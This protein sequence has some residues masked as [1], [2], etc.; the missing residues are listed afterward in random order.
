MK[1]KKFSCESCQELSN[2]IPLVEFLGKIMGNHCEVVLHDVTIPE[3]SVIAIANG[4]VSGRKVGAPITGYGLGLLHE[5][6]HLNQDFIHNYTS[7]LKNGKTAHS[8]T[9]FVKNSAGTVIGMLCINIDTDLLQCFRKG[10]DDIVCGYF[11]TSIINS[12]VSPGPH[13]APATAAAHAALPPRRVETFSESLEDLMYSLMQEALAAYTVPPDR[14]SAAERSEVMR[15]LHQW[16]FFKL[17][18]AVEYT[19]NTFGISEVTVYRYLKN[20]HAATPDM[21]PQ[22]G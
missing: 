14:F 8:S 22:A 15:Y 6:A 2:Y 1:T 9:F 3:K 16:G 19:A 13:P 17:R 7:Q 11:N 10:L 4:H 21:E 18:G 12:K 20:I 5:N